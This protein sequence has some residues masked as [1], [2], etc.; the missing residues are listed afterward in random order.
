ML[1]EIMVFSVHCQLCQ[2]VAAFSMEVG[3][4]VSWVL[5]PLSPWELVPVMVH[6]VGCVGGV[7]DVRVCLCM[8]VSWMC[9]CVS[10][11]LCLSGNPHRYR[12]TQ[13]PPP[14][15]HSSQGSKKTPCASSCSQLAAPVGCSS[16]FC[17]SL[18]FHTLILNKSLLFCM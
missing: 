11:R 2:G 18:R 13:Q 3:I 16:D 12:Q 1:S 6:H 14:F 17:G 8:Y 4:G 7:L 15:F 10:S 5:R 9:V